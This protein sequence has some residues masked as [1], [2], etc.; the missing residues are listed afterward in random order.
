MRALVVLELPLDG[1]LI[2]HLAQHRQTTPSAALQSLVN[3]IE[4]RLCDSVRPLDGVLGPVTARVHV[5]AV[6]DSW[7]EAVVA[8][9]HEVRS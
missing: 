2:Q 6:S 9:T 4:V 5:D 1:D 3:L 8:K 7:G